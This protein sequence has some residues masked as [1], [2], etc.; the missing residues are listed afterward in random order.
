MMFFISIFLG[1]AFGLFASIMAF[2]ITWNELEKHQFERKRL[3]NESLQAAG[4][5]FIFFLVLSM[6]AGYFITRYALK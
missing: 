6:L 2:V 3:V 1:S 4:F 5:T